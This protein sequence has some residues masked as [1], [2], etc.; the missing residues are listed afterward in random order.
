VRSDPRPAFRT[1]PVAAGVH[2]SA[3]HSLGLR[4]LVYTTCCGPIRTSGPKETG[5]K[6][7][8]AFGVHLAVGVAASGLAATT[9]YL[10]GLA[11]PADMLLYMTLGIGGSLAPDLDSDRSAP[12]RVL[13]TTISLS[14]AFLVLF[15]AADHFHS[16]AE[17]VLIWVVSFLGFRWAGFAVVVRLTQHR[18]IFHS[19]P[20]AVLAGAATAALGH[21][22]ARWNPM[23][24]WLAGAFVTFGYGVH[25]ALDELY[26]LNLFGSRARR[27][28][29]SALKLWSPRSGTATVAVYV[30]CLA[31]LSLAP[32]PRPMIT[33]VLSAATSASWWPDNGWFSGR[34]KDVPP[35]RG[36]SAVALLL[37]AEALFRLDRAHEN[38]GP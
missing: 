26:S 8:A 37:R 35:H 21:H 33:R 22:L 23:E 18:G 30:L 25:L 17:L 32:D 29:G 11:S 27:S 19:V 3:G 16:V 7:L 5:R 1:P 2:W 31:A 38:P 15:L 13:F 12:V 34:A 36:D 14:A 4:Y 6:G 20:A 9:V 28:F 24:A 10:A